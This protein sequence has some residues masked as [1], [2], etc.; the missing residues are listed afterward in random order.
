M[1]NINGPYS[2]LRLLLEKSILKENPVVAPTMAIVVKV[3]P[4]FKLLSLGSNSLKAIVKDVAELM[5]V[6]SEESL[7]NQLL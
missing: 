5:A 4:A 3:K 6:R 1:L 7:L 2:M